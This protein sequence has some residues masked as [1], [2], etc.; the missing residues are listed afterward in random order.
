MIFFRFLLRIKALTKLKKSPLRLIRLIFL[1]KI[2]NEWSVRL[3]NMLKKIETLR[4]V[5][6]LENALTHMCIT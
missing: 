1:K 6:M 4:T 5:L 2:L 3:S